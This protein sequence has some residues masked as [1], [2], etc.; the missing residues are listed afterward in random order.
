MDL[1]DLVNDGF[2]FSASDGK[3]FAA[4][5]AWKPVA[6]KDGIISYTDMQGNVEN[7]SGLSPDECAFLKDK[8]GI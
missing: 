3:N 7:L 1:R 8:H 5:K 6:I 4:G 2:D